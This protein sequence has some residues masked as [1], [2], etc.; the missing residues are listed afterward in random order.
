MH[1]GAVTIPVMVTHTAI[2]SGT[3]RF[4]LT[5]QVCTNEV[6]LRPKRVILPVRVTH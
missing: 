3:P 1:T 5:Y 6:C 4:V 2:W